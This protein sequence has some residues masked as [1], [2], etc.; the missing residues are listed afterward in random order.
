MREDIAG[1]Y[2]NLFSGNVSHFSI[3]N[4]FIKQLDWKI[5]QEEIFTESKVEALHY[6]AQRQHR[7]SFLFFFNYT[8]VNKSQVMPWVHV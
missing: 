5:P 2:R 7:C 3:K 6:G 4:D 1:I 8:S